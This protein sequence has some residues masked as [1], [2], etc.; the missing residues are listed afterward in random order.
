MRLVARVIALSALLAAVFAVADLRSSAAQ[1]P[2]KFKNLKVLPKDISKRE[3]VPIMRGYSQALGVRCNHCHF[4]KPGSTRFEDIDFASDENKRKDVARAMM[5]MVGSINDQISKTPI[6]HPT[7]VQ[8]VTCHRGVQ[9]PLTLDGVLKKSLDRKGLDAAIAEY[10]SLRKDYYGTGS[11]DF[12]ARTLADLAGDLADA[13]NL[14]AAQAFLNLNLEFNPDDANTHVTL[15]R[16]LMAKN[17][18]AGAQEHL[19]KA[20]ELDPNNRWAK[21]L[22]G[23]LRGE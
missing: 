7:E 12:S 5:K 16:V 1:I 19:E 21:E 6:K 13:G 9:D 22:L 11:Y 8:C 10:R 23:K 3:L 17:D 14:D 15:G 20:L 18:K 2:D 4:Q